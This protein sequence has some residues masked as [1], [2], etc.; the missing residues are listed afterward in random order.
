MIHHPSVIVADEPTGNLD[1][2]NTNCIA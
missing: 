2:L 1:D